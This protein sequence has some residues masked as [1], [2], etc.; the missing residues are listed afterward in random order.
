MF[1]F[2]DWIEKF[3]GEYSQ[4]GVAFNDAEGYG[5][6]IELSS[7]NWKVIGIHHLSPDE[8]NGNHNVFVEV[9]CKQNDREAFKAIHWTWQGK[10]NHEAAPDVFAGQ[11]PLNEL[12]DIPLNL[13]M[14]VSVW[15]HLGE[16]VVGLSSDHP[17]E[18]SGNTIGHH[19]FFVCFQEIEN[20]IITPEPEPEPD[21]PDTPGTN[22]KVIIEM[23]LDYLNTLQP[24]EQDNITFKIGEN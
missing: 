7:S 14:I 21:L 20:G 17:D 19:S 16:R 4:T 24:D 15:P 2:E 10:Q 5:I 22:T 3:Q 12:V 1:D 18:A 8:N 11:K 6:T 13:G 23:S 9:L